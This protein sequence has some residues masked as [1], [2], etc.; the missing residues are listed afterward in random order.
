L[1]GATNGIGE[2]A[3][4]DVT[5]S[6]GVVTNVTV[7]TKGKFYA[8]NDT[9]TISGYSIGGQVGNILSFTSNAS[10]KNGTE[11][12]YTGLTATGTGTGENATFDVSVDNNNLVNALS[13][14][15]SGDN[16]LPGNI[17]T[18]LGSQFGGVDGTDDITIEVTEVYSDN[19]TITISEISDIPSVYGSYNCNIFKRSD[20][21]NRLS[22]YDE[23]DILN[24]KEINK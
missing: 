16:Y 6:S 17:L 14:N 24:I 11:G 5:V 20:S 21:V 4:F 19:I 9:I 10:G 3:T 13:L 15:N 7:N 22:Y 2:N 23:N 12:S 8:I 1:T 18:I